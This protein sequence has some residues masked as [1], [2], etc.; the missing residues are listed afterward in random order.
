MYV[1]NSDIIDLLCACVPKIIMNKTDRQVFMSVTSSR[2]GR[3]KSLFC[4][5]ILSILEKE[6]RK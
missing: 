1:Y 2:F 6:T 4:K 5:L 3:S